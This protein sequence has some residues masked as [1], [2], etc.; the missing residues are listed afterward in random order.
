MAIIEVVFP[1]LKSDPESKKSLPEK[2][3][4]VVKSFQDGGVLRGVRGFLVSEDGKDV[5]ADYREV[6]VLE[7]ASTSDFHAFVASPTF[8]N[9]QAAIKPISNGPPELNVFETNDGSQLFGTHPVL[10]ILRIRPK[11]ASIDEHV[12]TILKK[13]QTKLHN[14]SEA[15]YGSSVNLP[16]KEVAVIKVFENKASLDAANN[17]SSRQELL[18]EIGD[19]AEVTRLVADIQQIPI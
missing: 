14:D 15:V 6:V 9:M 10:E 7:W 4:I 5:S 2:L 16:Q 18:K 13:L 8:A 19:L 1:Q 11:G 12:Q 3:P 17:A